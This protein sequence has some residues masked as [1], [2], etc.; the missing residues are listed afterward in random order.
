MSRDPRQSPP[1]ALAHFTL[2]GIEIV[3]VQDGMGAALIV[4]GVFVLAWI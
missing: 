3:R 2:K 1:R 4:G